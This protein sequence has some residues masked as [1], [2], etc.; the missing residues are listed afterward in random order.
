MV[1]DTRRKKSDEVDFVGTWKLSRDRTWQASQK[2]AKSTTK[3][4]KFL[5]ENFVRKSQTI[6]KWLKNNDTRYVSLAH[7]RRQVRET[8]VCLHA[9]A[10]FHIFLSP[11][12][13]F[14]SFTSTFFFLLALLF[15]FSRLSWFVFDR[16]RRYRFLFFFLFTVSRQVGLPASPR[17]LQKKGRGARREERNVIFFFCFI[18]IAIE[19]LATDTDHDRSRKKIALA[20]RGT[21]RARRQ[22]RR[23]P[24]AGVYGVDRAATLV[25]RPLP[26]PSEGHGPRKRVH[27]RYTHGNLSQELVTIVIN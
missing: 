14:L 3:I 17:V 7:L 9:R 18:S 1:T 5:L 19:Y 16:S 4:N 11:V 22:H 15:R 10:P 21:D 2:N 12:I 23:G 13:V 25:A 20:R 26:A 24:W 27:I 8:H 6:T